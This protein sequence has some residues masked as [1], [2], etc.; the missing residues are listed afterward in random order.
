M[1][2]AP[3]HAAWDRRGQAATELGLGPGAFDFEF[4]EEDWVDHEDGRLA[5]RVHEIYRL[6]NTGEF[7]YERD[8][9]VELEI[10]DGKISR[11]EMRIVG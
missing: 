5:C 3:A 1:G 7:A 11:Y 10:R 8:R 6:K 4:R 9:V 2:H